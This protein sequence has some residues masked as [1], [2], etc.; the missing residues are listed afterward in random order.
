MNAPEGESTDRQDEAD[1]KDLPLEE[2][3]KEKPVVKSSVESEPEEPDDGDVAG[4]KPNL[5]PAMPPMM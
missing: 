1:E 4:D 2:I 5:P 3:V